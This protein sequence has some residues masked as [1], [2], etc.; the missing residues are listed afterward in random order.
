MRQPP[1]LSRQSSVLPRWLCLL[2][3]AGGLPACLDD[4]VTEGTRVDAASG[5]NADGDATVH[6]TDATVAADA[7][8]PA[9]S[10][11][12]DLAP[13]CPAGLGGCF[14][15][16]R[17]VCNPTGSALLKSPCT[18]PQAC[19]NGTCVDCVTDSECKDDRAC[20]AGQ[21]VLA[22][23]SVATVGL[24]PAL[25]GSPYSVTLLAKGGTPPYLWSLAQGVLPAGILLDASGKLAGTAKQKSAS[26]FQIQVADQAG[27]KATAILTLDVADAGL[28]IASA[29]PLPAATEGEP[30]TFTFTAQG[31]TAPYFWGVTGGKLPPGLGLGSDGALT[32]TPSADGAFTFDLKVLDNSSPTLAAVESFKL[33][34]K[35]APL[36]IVGTQQVNLFI[37]KIIVLP[38]IL[39]VDKV[40]VPYSTKLQAKGGKKPY[41]WVEQPL[42][43][44]VKSFIPK[45][46]I[47]AGLKLAADGT[48]SGAVS[49]ASLVVEVK[50]PLGGLNL[51]GFFF[52]AEVQ[53]SQGKPDKKTALFIIP[54]V[55]VGGP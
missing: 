3:L 29:S 17:Y 53:D 45:S 51:K 19:H 33:P 30:Y 15:G 14:G 27:Q 28:V 49:D 41:A 20:K 1:H 10:L 48:I 5:Q 36:E 2:A 8:A 9:D 18:A 26:S 31:G 46:G 23:L 25:V 52:A 55:P 38:L 34:V 44:V 24:A 40:P 32:G 7:S 13:L 22:P 35:L 4:D 37:T 12:A 21:C 54:T 42:P 50:L 16:E 43:G 47:P 39:V 6:A 11:A